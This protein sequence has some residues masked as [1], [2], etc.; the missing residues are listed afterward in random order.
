LLCEFEFHVS[1]CD[2]GV[3]SVDSMVFVTRVHGEATVLRWCG[4]NNLVAR[5]VLAML[6]HLQ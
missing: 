1:D 2:D 4:W 3:L 5:D 6:Q